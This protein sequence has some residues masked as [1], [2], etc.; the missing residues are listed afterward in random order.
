MKVEL[1]VEQM[2][3]V[4][5]ALEAQGRSMRLAASKQRQKAIQAVMLQHAMAATELSWYFAEQEAQHG[6]GDVGQKRS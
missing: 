4:R 2:T 1:S 6:K 3:A 5:E